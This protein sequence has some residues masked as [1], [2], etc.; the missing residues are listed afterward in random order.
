MWPQWLH[1]GCIDT[2]KDQAEESIESILQLQSEGVEVIL[3]QD[4][5]GKKSQNQARVSGPAP[6]RERSLRGSIGTISS[7]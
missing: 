5:L 4:V 7:L 1:I 3:A 6:L 2:N